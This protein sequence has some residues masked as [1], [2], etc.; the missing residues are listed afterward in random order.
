MSAA[1]WPA[2]AQRLTG[3]LW[4]HYEHESLPPDC[5]CQCD[6]DGSESRSVSLAIKNADT[7][8]QALPGH[9]HY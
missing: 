1:S 8:R 6:S 4:R 3:R 7:L 5:Q 2:R 9:W